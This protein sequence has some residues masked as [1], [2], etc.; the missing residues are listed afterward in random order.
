MAGKQSRKE[1]EQKVKA[2]YKDSMK[3]LINEVD[4]KEEL[5]QLKS[6]LDNALQEI[7]GRDEA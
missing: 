4:N 2:E 1:Q 5:S 6:A 3:K 7:R